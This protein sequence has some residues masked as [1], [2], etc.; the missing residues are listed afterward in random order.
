M[1]GDIQGG[2][3]DTNYGAGGIVQ[4]FDGQ[5]IDND[6]AGKSGPDVLPRAYSAF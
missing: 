3:S 5:V 4:W 2:A 1:S 6:L